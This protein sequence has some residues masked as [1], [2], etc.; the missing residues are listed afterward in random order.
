MITRKLLDFVIMF[1]IIT[2]YHYI[3]IHLSRYHDN[4]I[5]ISYHDNLI[6]LL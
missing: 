3:M 2:Q 1:G 5:M 6:P 4:V